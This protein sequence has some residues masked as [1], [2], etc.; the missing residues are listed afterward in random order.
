LWGML[1]TVLRFIPYVGPCI[2]AAFPIVLAFS[3]DPGW[4][5][6]I[7]T[8]LLFVVLEIVASNFIETWLFGSSMGISSVAIL[9]S[10]L[11][12]A[13]LWGPIGLIVS[14]PLTVCF[15]VLGRYIPA[16]QRFSLLLGDQPGLPLYA[17]MYQRFLAMDPDE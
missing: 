12:W 6:V 4:R 1:A 13:W 5:M 16:L 14:T 2:A 10:A 11:F 15:V 9:L 7:E 8:V 17:R 3:V